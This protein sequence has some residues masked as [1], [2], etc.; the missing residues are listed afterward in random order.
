MKRE[1][2]LL[3]SLVVAGLA[4]ILLVLPQRY[5]L[6]PRPLGAA[7]AIVLIAIVN[8]AYFSGEGSPW[9]RLEYYAVLVFAAIVTAVEIVILSRLLDDMAFRNSQIGALPLLS[10]AVGIWL[11]NVVTFALFYWKIDAADF[12]F[13]TANSAKAPPNWEPS[14]IDYLFLAYNTSTA[15]SPTDALPI[16][17]R[18]KAFMMTQSLI[19]LV[20]I[21][22]VAARAIN[23]LGS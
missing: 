9:R 11:T 3:A 18:A 10:T 7:V 6:L 1:S 22:A 15:F 12:D 2:P 8:R 4:A 21:V 16:T 19:S 14:F 17:G 23:I 20:T 5:E 13:P